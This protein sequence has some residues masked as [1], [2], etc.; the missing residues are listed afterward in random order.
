MT[1]RRFWVKDPRHPENVFAKTCYFFR[2]T[3]QHQ[4]GVIPVNKLPRFEL[5]R[6]V[7]TRSIRKNISFKL[8]LA[9]CTV[10]KHS[11]CTDFST[12]SES[13]LLCAFPGAHCRVR[14][15]T[16]RHRCALYP[17]VHSTRCGHTSDTYRR[18]EADEGAGAAVPEMASHSTPFSGLQVLHR[19]PMWASLREG[20]YKPAPVR[21]KQGRPRAW[22]LVPPAARPPRPRRHQDYSSP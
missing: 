22:T 17:C 13:L 14:V 6:K 7:T 4:R 3:R 2:S 18:E 1:I 20:S 5:V 11:G 12:V 21:H 10:V 15:C 19:F 16:S 9:F 8:L